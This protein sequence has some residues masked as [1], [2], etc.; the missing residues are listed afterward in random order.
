MKKKLSAIFALSTA[1]VTVAGIGYKLLKGHNIINR[2][3]FNEEHKA[4]ARYVEANH[5][6]ATYSEIRDTGDSHITIITDGE[7]KYLLTVTKSNDGTYI[8]QEE[9]LT[10]SF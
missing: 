6:N 2:V 8:Y 3:K 9:D 1:A 5:P 10:Y 7:Y 4:V